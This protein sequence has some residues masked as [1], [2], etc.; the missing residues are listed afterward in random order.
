M[1]L[2]L[3]RNAVILDGL[4]QT[5]YREI[6]DIANQECL[7][8][9]VPKKQQYERVHSKPKQKACLRDTLLNNEGPL[10]ILEW[11]L[12]NPATSTIML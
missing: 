10:P 6:G 1:V 8:T 5:N 12:K 11:M 9:Q 4:L 2:W 3:R 7:A